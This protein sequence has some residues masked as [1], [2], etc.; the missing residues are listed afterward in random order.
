VPLGSYE[1]WAEWVR[2]P[3]HA[4]G[5]ADPVERISS[6]KAGDPYRKQTAELL[7]CWHARYG[8]APV[9]AANLDQAVKVIVDPQGRGRQYLVSRLDKLADTRVAGLVLTAQRPA[10]KW[11]ATTYAVRSTSADGAD[12]IGHRGHRPPDTVPSA[13]PMPPL[14]YDTGEAAGLDDILTLVDVLGE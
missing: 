2:D 9:T 11:G 8:D 6:V 3:L 1:T 5:C 10:G 7:V 13:N 12:S 14:P 4:L